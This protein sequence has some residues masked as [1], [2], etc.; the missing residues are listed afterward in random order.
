MVGIEEM[1][2]VETETVG[3]VVV[4]GAVGKIINKKYYK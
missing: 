1:M 4:D 3:K 2:T